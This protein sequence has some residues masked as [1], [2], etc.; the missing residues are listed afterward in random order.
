MSERSVVAAA[1]QPKAGAFPRRGGPS[2]TTDSYVSLHYLWIKEALIF[3]AIA[4]GYREFPEDNSRHQRPCTRRDREGRYMHVRIVV[5]GVKP[6]RVEARPQG[7][8]IHRR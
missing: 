7:L 1:S 5:P 6:V 4:D 3:R 2:G 8:D